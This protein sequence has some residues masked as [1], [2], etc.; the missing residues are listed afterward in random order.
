MRWNPRKYGSRED[1]IHQSDMAN[2]FGGFGCMSKFG[3]YKDYEAKHGKRYESINA[4][5]ARELGTAVHEVIARVLRK[6]ESRRA[7]LDGRL[8]TERRVMMALE[9]EF[10]KACD[11]RP[12]KWGKSSE[13]AELT[14]GVSMVRN[15][16][17][18][19]GERASKIALVE[20]GFVAP[21]ESSTGKTYWIEG[22]IDLAF[23][24]HDG[25]IELADWKTGA[26]RP[27]PVGLNRGFQL[28]LYAY[29]LAHGTFTPGHLTATRPEYPVAMH[30][31]HLRDFVPYKKK[32]YKKVKAGA[33][34]A[35]Y[36]VEAG[37]RITL[38]A[39]QL[40]GPGWY[41]SERRLDDHQDMVTSLASIVSV[42]R[43]G[44]SWKAIGDACGF[45]PFRDDCASE[46][47]RLDDSEARHLQQSLK[48]IN[49]EGLA[50]FD[51]D[52]A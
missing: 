27:T 48:G 13:L 33:E 46:G 51:A 23:F 41:R 5:G 43:M 47:Y 29:A 34:A 45:C 32:S 16:L 37:T 40:R 8:P 42:V 19:L 30:I 15:G 20:A 26:Q 12:V 28:G 52:A 2:L 44:R 31:I 9:E 25:Q 49:L 24:N 50:D 35:F 39:G 11:G 21:I 38:E 14:A 6:D 1:P 17:R 10:A 7:V 4:Q 3:R 36:G 22:T 18:T